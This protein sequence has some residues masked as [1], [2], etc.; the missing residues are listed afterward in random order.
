ME[1]RD[2]REPKK[3]QRAGLSRFFTDKKNETMAII[4]VIL[5]LS[6][7]LPLVIT[8]YWLNIIY[9]VA[10]GAF[11][12]MEAVI[13]VAL[14]CF[15]L[16][17][18]IIALV[19]VLNKKS[20][21]YITLYY[22]FH[23][24]VSL[25]IVFFSPY[26]VFATILSII[27]LVLA[28]KATN[29]DRKFMPKFKT[30]QAYALVLVAIISV[31]I[32]A[33][34]YFN[35]P[36][37][38][39]TIQYDSNIVASNLEV[40]FALANG[41]E[42]PADLLDIMVRSNA[43]P[44]LN[45]SFE[46]PILEQLIL[47]MTAVFN[48]TEPKKEDY[49]LGNY[50]AYNGNW[51]AYKADMDRYSRDWNN[52]GREVFKAVSNLSYED[53]ANIPAEHF[54]TD[55]LIANQTR[56]FYNNGLSVDYMPLLEAE[57][58]INDFT[59]VR[60]NKTLMLMKRFIDVSGLQQKHRGLIIDTER[61][62]GQDDKT[63]AEFHNYQL[64]ET[65]LKELGT[66]VK[67]LKMWEWAWKN[68]TALHGEYTPAKWKTHMVDAKKTYV[69]SATFGV[70]IDDLWDKD[71]AQQN[72]FKISIVTAKDD[73]QFDFIGIMTYETGPNSDHAVYGYCRA[74]DYFFG[75]AN[76][77]YIYSGI[78]NFENMQD[79]YDYINGIMRKFLIAR[80][81]GYSVTGIWGLTHM[82]CHAASGFNQSWCG[83]LYD[84]LSIFGLQEEI[85]N[86]MVNLT[87]PSDVTIKVDSYNFA[88]IHSGVTFL[89]L[90]LTSETRYG[91]WPIN[92]NPRIRPNEF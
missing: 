24:L 21:L 33:A 76:V 66:V 75:K 68:G 40:N 11:F 4:S 6:T 61:M 20:T 1:N 65:G 83:G 46:M 47:N 55:G 18:F 16:G 15:S 35:P 69:G 88:I 14:A 38:T 82:Y 64:H 58:Y 39:Y 5:W 53:I 37:Y 36:T 81:Y 51:S 9:P 29:K 78:D 54:L 44:G 45:V 67:Q 56:M 72:L 12:S 77:P 27:G 23:L 48:L 71:D 8:A 52:Y 17:A 32:P 84:V 79:P 28:R 62:W 59:V 42:M 49:V 92:N 57:V 30:K 2:E 7:F 80:N 86:M 85:Y 50:T 41:T 60:F 19:S 87:N 43:L 25:P 22:G 26:W 91:D 73:E 74:G 10:V 89:D 90:Y 31:M 70:H 34:A 13:P 63:I 3:D